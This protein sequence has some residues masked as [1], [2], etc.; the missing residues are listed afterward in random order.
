[1]FTGKG[2]GGAG[3]PTDPTA[4]AAAGADGV[5]P[6][7]VKIAGEDHTLRAVGPDGDATVEMASGPFGNLV[8]RMNELIKQL[9]KT[10]T[11]P[12]AEKYLGDAKAAKINVDLDALAIKA[13]EVVNTV[14]TAKTKSTEGKAVKKG[15]TDLRTMINAL[16]LEGATTTVL[17]GRHEVKAGP[18]TT[19]GRQ[20]WFEVSYLCA[21]SMKRGGPAK[22]PVPGVKI[23]EGYHQ[24]HLAAGSLGGPGTPDNLVPMS[25][26]TNLTRP[27]VV[28]LEDE[29][30]YR[31]D[32]DS[33]SRFPRKHPDAA[34]PYVFRYKVTAVYHP[35]GSLQADLDA[36]GVA[37][38]DSE[39]K[40]FA[41]AQAATNK[42]PT[43]AAIRALVKLPPNATQRDDDNLPGNVR[44]RL[45]DWFMPHT[46]TAEREVK[47]RP[48]TWDT[49]IREAQPTS[50]HLGVDRHWV[51]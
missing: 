26:E 1:L 23:I 37:L 13:Q 21:D 11:T 36:H 29:L 8:S 24:G 43:D 2:K 16:G 48:T 17:H 5:E 30:R 10:Y 50:N 44:R 33:P 27:G 18:A 38:S 39:P 9:K 3:S 34:P 32:P 20:K 12:G 22:G 42:V 7:M 45:V 28:G 40:L 14:A 31:L 25:E 4:D 41:L 46:I 15:F 35:D 49:A 19:Y 51:S 47:Q 6:E